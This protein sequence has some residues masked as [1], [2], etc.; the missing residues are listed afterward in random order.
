MDTR[1]V[2]SR[3]DEVLTDHRNTNEPCLHQLSISEAAKEMD[4]QDKSSN[5][6]HTKG[7]NANLSSNLHMPMSGASA[8]TS[9]QEKGDVVIEEK[10]NTNISNH[11][12]PSTTEHHS[13]G[14]LT[15]SCNINISGNLHCWHLVLGDYKF[16]DLAPYSCTNQ[17][18]DWYY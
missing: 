14:I 4:L 5:T 7:S 15:D 12:Y 9:L 1:Q 16:F 13:V 2:I 11:V 17:I 18:L 8:D 6:V 3:S 10:G